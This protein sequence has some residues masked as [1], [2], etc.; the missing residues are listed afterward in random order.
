MIGRYAT[1]QKRTHRNGYRPPLNVNP[2]GGGSQLTV[3][4]HPAMRNHHHCH[5]ATTKTAFTILKQNATIAVIAA[6]STTPTA[7]G[8]G[9]GGF[10]AVVVMLV[11]LWA[12]G[13]DGGGDDGSSDVSLGASNQC[14]WCCCCCCVTAADGDGAPWR[15]AL[16][17]YAP[18]PFP[19]TR[20]HSL[21]DSFDK[22]NSNAPLRG[23]SFGLLPKK[24]RPS[25]VHR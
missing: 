3:V 10:F 25:G 2:A 15:P 19:I 1:W 21:S 17:K 4:L 22:R 6:T 13:V 11:W 7:G 9:G 12:S 16:R 20:A 23:L 8:G 14:C 5:C 24:K 18:T